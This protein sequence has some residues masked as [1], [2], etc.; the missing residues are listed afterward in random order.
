MLLRMIAKGEM[1]CYCLV[2]GSFH[3]FMNLL[4]VIGTLIGESGLKEILD[5][6][7]GEN[8]II[9]IMSGKAAE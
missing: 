7:Y 9:L 4:G 1:W 6:V 5:T 3:T 2:F 8:T